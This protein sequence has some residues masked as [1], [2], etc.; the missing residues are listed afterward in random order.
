[1]Q[2]KNIG[3]GSPEAIWLYVKNGH[4]ATL[5]KDTWV[6]YAFASGSRDGVSVV[7][8]T[9]ASNAT[10]VAGVVPEA[11]PV[12]EKG[13]ICVWGV[14]DGAMCVGGAAGAALAAGSLLGVK[15]NGG[16]AEAYD[17]AAAYPPTGVFLEP[18]YTAGAGTSATPFHGRVMVRCL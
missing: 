4:N 16:N 18:L 5:A 6:A 2:F 12:G 7:P 3:P 10:M 14:Y 15:T 11:I 8:I 1:M 9:A 17:T 13:Y